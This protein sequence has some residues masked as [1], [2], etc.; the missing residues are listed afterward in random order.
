MTGGG[1]LSLIAYGAQNVIL[2]GNPQMTYFYKAFKRY[3]HFAMENITIPLDG[4]NELAFDQPVKLRAKIP[5]FGDL[6]NDMV[7][8]FR[9]P[10]IYSK[11]ISSR[12]AQYEF[13][14]VRY[15][16]AAIIQSAA[17]FV[18]GQK[19]QEFDGNYLLSRALIDYDQD[20]F[21]KWR[22]L[23]GDVP[24]LTNPA[25]GA[26]AG[27][28]SR[29]QYPTVVQDPTSSPGQQTNRP[30][31]FG[32]EISIPL[33]FWFCESASQ[34]LPLVGLQYHECEV[35]LMLNPISDL[36]SIL[37]ASGYRVNQ[38]F[39]MRS[40]LSDIRRNNPAYAAS[41]DISGQIRN[42]FVD[43][44][45]STPPLNSWF[46]NPRLQGNFIYLP[47]DEQKIFAVRPLSY[48]MR[49]VTNYPFPGLFNRQVLDVETH[50]PITRIIF[51]QR[52]SDALNR[53]D[54]AN[55][56][57]WVNYPLS[58]YEPTQGAPVASSGI[59]LPNVQQEMIRSIRVLC[60]GNEIQEQKPVDFFTNYSMYR[61][62]TGI[63]DDG[64]PFYS[65]QLDQTATQPSGSINA[66]RIRNFQVEL[67]VFPLP[68]N[69]A[70]TYDVN[71][72]V[73][74]L[75]FFEVASGMG[76]LKYAL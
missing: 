31:I 54:Y 30:S 46:I 76:G 75:N 69:P 49:Q 52:R 20:S 55:F 36:Y 2:S 62:S 50:N 53:N 11:Y 27:G 6:V 40:S 33:N 7:F 4:S 5:R 48:I 38:D 28:P 19:I 66:S 70:Y 8:T 17:I 12:G 25:T 23:V 45:F 24:E 22:K 51:V 15:L 58:P 13:Q 57:N 21:Y 37:D 14:W 18:G 59:L 43:F 1:I 65:F 41:S 32:R 63:G 29:N 64:L 72:Y 73:E 9:I 44:G 34:A 35:Q 74:N 16:G 67:D 3:S 10:D 68:L 47:A 71:F 42:F 60:D 26:Y 39:A 56:T 61:Y